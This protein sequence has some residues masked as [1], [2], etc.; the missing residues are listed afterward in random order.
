MHDPLGVHLGQGV[1]QLARDLRAALPGERA[2]AGD[3]GQLLTGDEVRDDVGVAVGRALEVDDPHDRRVAHL[4]QEL[5]L[6]AKAL[7]AL[8]RGVPRVQELERQPA[9]AA[10]G[11]DLVDDPRA[12]ATQLADDPVVSDLQPLCHDPNDSRDRGLGPS[13]RPTVAQAQG[14]LGAAPRDQGARP[15]PHED[16]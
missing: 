14:R 2:T 12:A 9:L 4:R 3:L 15:L 8:R 1:G 6:A 11:D 10:L 13:T 5:R 7:Q 16:S